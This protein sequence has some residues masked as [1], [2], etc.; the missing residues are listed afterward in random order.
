MA[1]PK[2][3]YVLPLPVVGWDL[4]V[5]AFSPAERPTR[6][7]LRTLRN[8][9][10]VQGVQVTHRGEHN[11]AGSGTYFSVLA[12]FAAHAERDGRPEEAHELA[13]AAAALETR[14]KPQ[15]T[16]FLRHN[17]LRDLPKA[18]FFDDL[19][20]ATAEVMKSWLGLRPGGTFAAAVKDVRG[21]FARLDAYLV[22]TGTRTSL[23]LPK[24][25]LE[26]AKLG[27]N[28]CAWVFSSTV[29]NTGLVELLPAVNVRRALVGST[30]EDWYTSVVA[31]E[32]ADDSMTEAEMEAV[33]D[34]YDRLAG[35]MSPARIA[36]ARRTASDRG[37]VRQS[38]RLV[39]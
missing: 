9:H 22:F 21:P 39:G 17:D 35:P 15:L 37:F 20:R 31:S 34:E 33:A 28:D 24:E 18:P 19:M 11:A 29:E 10:G 6:A 1:T 30:L 16:G 13:T 2:R 26:A 8:R 25:L 36:A 14:F 3:N 32:A 7:K 4:L 12:V 23:D 27:V 38:V 5:R